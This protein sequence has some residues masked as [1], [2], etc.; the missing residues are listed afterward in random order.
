MNKNSCILVCTHKEDKNTRNE[1]IYKAIQVGCSLCPELDLGY[2]KDNIGD[3]ISEKNPMYC[4]LT[5]LYWGWKN[6]KDVQYLGLCHYRRYFDI[7]FNKFDI[8][9]VLSKDK[10]IVIKNSKPMLSKRERPTNLINVTSGEDYYLYLDTMM[11]FYPQYK[12]EIINYFYNSRK[13]FPYTMFIAKKEIYDDFCEFIFPVFFEIEK[14]AKIHGY[15]RQKRF[16]GYFGE[17][18][19]GLYI[20]C[21]HLMPF[22][23]EMEFCGEQNKRPINFFKRTWNTLFILLDNF[24]PVPDEIYVPDPIK[25]GFR[26]D[27][28]ELQALK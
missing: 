11:S 21:K 12:K 13:S 27:K 25:V 7:D 8:E 19:L 9:K 5:A 6:I 15:T 17:Y 18:S 10:I 4:E 23:V 16:M 22:T 3:N 14:K 1:G 2:L 24:L 26:A 28:I 20:M